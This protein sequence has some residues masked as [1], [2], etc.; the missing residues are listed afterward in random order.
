[1]LLQRRD[2]AAALLE[3]VSVSAQTGGRTHI[4]I[5]AG[6]F[7]AKALAT[8]G[9]TSNALARL[10][11]ILPLAAPEGYFS[12]FV[13]EGETLR[14]L[15]Q[16]ARAK[17]PAEIRVYVEQMLAAFSTGENQPVKRETG[18]GAP[19]LSDREREIL[20]LVAEGL[21]N[22]EIAERLVISITTVKTHVGNIF[23]KLGVTSR[24][25]AIA[26]AE[27]LGLLLRR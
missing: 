25:Q 20:L 11:E 27:G 8:Q 7:Q 5:R 14:Q 18:Y 4:V 23:N 13:D 1:M 15:L 22:Q 21:S 26:R 24:I 12:T 19:E 16:E 2:E 17:V 3:K 6:V 9:K 10:L